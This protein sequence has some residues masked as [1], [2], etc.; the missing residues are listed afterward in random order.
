M[1]NKK[2][3]FILIAIVLC[4]LSIAS[5]L[6]ASNT[7]INRLSL[8]GLKGVYV[9]VERIEPEIEKDGLTKNHIRRDVELKLRKTG[10]KTL[11]KDEWFN[12]IGSPYLY[13]N[14]NVMK[15][16]ASKEYI[17]SVNIALRQNVY[18]VREPIEV[19]GATTWSIGGIVGITYNLNKIRSSVK[20]QVDKFIKAY[21]A[22]NR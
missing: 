13:V 12:T 2:Q 18:P 19:I 8:R 6:F 20:S 16:R 17:Y 15:L 14:V 4:Q 7:T 10:I 1:K 9:E 3:L 5:L 22:V 11:S 21:L